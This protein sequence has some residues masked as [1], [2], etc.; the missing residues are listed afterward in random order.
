MRRTTRTHDLKC[1]TQNRIEKTIQKTMRTVTR[2]RSHWRDKMQ[3]GPKQGRA[4]EQEDENH[5]NSLFMLLLRPM[6]HSMLSYT[7]SLLCATALWS[8]FRL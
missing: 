8:A 4:R 1:M 6:L 2:E 5:A 3:G 7:D